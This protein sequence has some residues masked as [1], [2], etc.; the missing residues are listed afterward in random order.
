MPN[1]SNT[2][3]ACIGDPTEIRQLHNAIKTNARRKTSRVKNGFGTLWLGNIIDQL[4]GNW[5]EWKCRGEITGFQMEKGDK[6][7]T[8]YQSTAWCEQEGFRKFIEKKFPSIK[9]YYLDIEPGC[10]WYGT[11]DN[12][13]EYFPERYYLESYEDTEMFNTIEEAAEFVSGI[14]NKKVEAKMP[15]IEKALDE[16]EDVSEND[17]VYFSFHQIQVVDD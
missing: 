6:K 7:L 15:A 8:I 4:G 11:N 1:W 16:Y 17:D 9:V 2:L 13:G 12:T 3:Y 10:G 5:E 14:V